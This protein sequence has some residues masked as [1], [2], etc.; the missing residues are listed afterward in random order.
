GPPI[1][2]FAQLLDSADLCSLGGLRP[3]V[4]EPVLIRPDSQAVLELDLKAITEPGMGADSAVFE[5]EQIPAQEP[6]PIP[7]RPSSPDHLDEADLPRVPWDLLRADERVALRRME[8]DPEQDGPLGRDAQPSE[9]VARGVEGG[10]DIPPQE[11]LVGVGRV[12]P[13]LD[14]RE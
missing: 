2:G 12:G 7:H 4:E 14:R 1:Q 10:E 13:A 5:G 3:L 11:S 9:E 6:A 8:P